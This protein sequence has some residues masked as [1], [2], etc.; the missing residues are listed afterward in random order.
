MRKPKIEIIEQVLENIRNENPDTLNFA[1]PAA[2]ANH[3]AGFML[4]RQD[5][6]FV[7]DALEKI[8]IFKEQAEQQGL[9]A[10]ATITEGLWYS[11]ICVYGKCFNSNKGGLS[12][13]E[14]KDIFGLTENDDLRKMHI[15]IM[16][17]RNSFVA[18]RDATD[19]EGVVVFMKIPRAGE[20][21]DLT[22]FQMRSYQAT[23][24]VPELIT[25]IDI[26]NFVIEKV[27]SKIESKMQRVHD[28]YLRNF[29]PRL[30]RHLMI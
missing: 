24:L 14:E 3:V 6:L 11:T 13:L 2:I 30:M 29:E 1:V 9:I 27:E 25:F 8:I 7:K 19:L 21:G 4:I 16:G 10:D 18:H 23:S 15:K 5:L 20:L 22:E 17:Y 26:V 12:S 28:G